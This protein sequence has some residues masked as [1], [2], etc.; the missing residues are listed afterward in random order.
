MHFLHTLASVMLQHKRHLAFGI[1][2]FF[3]TVYTLVFLASPLLG[4][5]DDFVFLRTLQSGKPLIYNSPDFPYYDSIQNGRFSPLAS[6]EYNL[7]GYISRS[8]LAYFFFHAVQFVFLTIIL[9]RVLLST[10]LPSKIA[11]LFSTYL[12]LLPGF[13]ITWFRLQLTERNVLFFGLFFTLVYSLY[14][15]KK[16]L[17]LIAAALLLANI[18][19][20]YKETAFLMVGG[21]A[22]ASIALTWRTSSI[23]DK[24]LAWGLLVSSAMYLVL[25]KL[26]ILPKTDLAFFSFH[27]NSERLV[28]I[29]KNLFNFTTFSDPLLFFGLLPLVLYRLYQILLKKESSHELYDPLL[30]GSACFV[31]GYLLLGFYGPYYVV[32]AYAF[33][34][35]GIAYF[36][37]RIPRNILVIPLSIIGCISLLNTIPAGIHYITYNKYLPINFN[38]TLDFLSQRIALEKKKP[39]SLFIDSVPMEKGGRGTYGIL[40]E[41]L[42]FRGFSNK[43]FDLKSI[44]KRSTTDHGMKFRQPYSVFSPGV[45]TMSKGDLL[46]LTP[47]TW[48]QYSTDDF[49]EFRRDYVLL[50]RTHS[51]LFY[52]LLTAK[53]LLKNYIAH[54]DKATSL[55]NNQNIL[56]QVDYYVYE[57]K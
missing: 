42:E 16:T 18:C 17:P 26:L 30:F 4:P 10:R 35:P 50:F 1:F 47:Q 11:Y 41:F 13:T 22:F 19:I 51:P 37:K 34:I 23:R 20:Y 54:T 44:E 48:K 29:I 5:T 3:L 39:L 52:P 36:A 53:T 27:Q 8:P 28:A 9:F 31:G 2:L 32:P 56:E 25:Y 46:I 55:V 24:I 14:Q 38:K 49:S 43:E 57:K 40:A 6:L 7:M 21:F 33:A 12:F 45:E 15:K